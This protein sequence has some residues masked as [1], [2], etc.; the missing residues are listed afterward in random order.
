MV[1][2]GIKRLLLDS[3][4][5]GSVLTFATAE[6]LLDAFGKELRIDLCLLE[7]ELPGLGG[8]EALLELQGRWRDLPVIILT[9]QPAKAV[10][11]RALRSG[12]RGFLSKGQGPD[13]LFAAIENVL[14]G[15]RAID[16]FVVDLILSSVDNS[17]GSLPH[18]SLSDREFNIMRRIAAGEPINS[19]ASD[20][21][22]SPKTV[23]TYRRRCL[24]KMGLE[25][26]SQLTEYAMLHLS[27]STPGTHNAYQVIASAG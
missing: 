19:I 22:L 15:G 14:A 12:A 6:E 10:A 24:E 4:V 13:E 17:E 25:R 18:E 27:S 7:I 20:L 23:S 11:V 8:F 26:N 2:E 9:A 5:V 21:C 3:G 1:R 16:P